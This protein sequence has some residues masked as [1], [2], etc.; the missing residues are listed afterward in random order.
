MKFAEEVVWEI[1]KDSNFQLA[2]VGH[3]S[4]FPPCLRGETRKEERQ[5]KVSGEA[6][7]EREKEIGRKKGELELLKVEKTLCG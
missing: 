2:T 7:K 6:E 3:V 5:G 4:E 1:L